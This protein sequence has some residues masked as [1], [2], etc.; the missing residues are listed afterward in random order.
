MD[1]ADAFRLA[2]AARARGDAFRGF[3]WE[4][5]AR[6]IKERKPKCAEAGLEGDWDCTGGVIYQD[7]KTV[8][9]SYAFLSSNWAIPQLDLDG[10]RIDC[11]VVLTDPKSFNPT[12][13]WPVAAI[14]ILGNDD[15]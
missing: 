9:D 11:W 8:T 5:A 4:T 3:D 7:G 12:E 1:T 15:E 13:L 10:E 14:E 6:L 2:R